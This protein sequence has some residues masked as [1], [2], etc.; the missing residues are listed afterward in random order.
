MDPITLAIPTTAYNTYCS[1]AGQGIGSLDANGWITIT[2]L[3]LVLNFSVAAVLYAISGI[4]PTTYREKLK[5]AVKYEAFQGII[6]A[7]I[8]AILIA[9]SAS[10]CYVGQA[11]VYQSTTAQYQNPIQYSELYT[12]NLMFNTGLSLFTSIYSE[13]ILLTLTGNIAEVLEE[14]LPQI[15]I[16]PTL[17]FTVGSGLIGIF[18][19]FSGALTSTFLALIAVTFGILFVVYLILP[20]IQQ[21]AFTVVLPIALILRS[22]PFAGPNLRQT[23]DTMLALAIG[24]YFIFPLTIL[25]NNFIMQWIYTSC[26]PGI[27]GVVP[28]L[29]NPYSQYTGQYGL[30]NL[31]ISSLFN[32]PPQNLDSVGFLGGIALPD[33]FYSSSYNG[34]GGLGSG[35]TLILENLYN[36]PNLILTYAQK[37]AQYLFQGIFLIGLDLAITVGFAMGLSKGLNSIGTMIGVGPFWSG[38]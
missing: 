20:F 35:I 11:L 37:T 14:F 28:S 25:M 30:V 1:F 12:S 10:L 16:L 7:V 15:T 5:G 17:S 21:L 22:I 4:L 19:G 27:N 26:V 2:S 8:L 32:L 34:F 9:S 29:C 6:S 24:F 23:S 36:T 33:T 3:V 13:S 38:Y 31:P 18:Y